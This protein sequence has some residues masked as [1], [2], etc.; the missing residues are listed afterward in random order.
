MEKRNY[1]QAACAYIDEKASFFEKTSDYIWDHPELSLKEYKATAWYCEKL[2]ELGYSCT[3]SNAR[4]YISKTAKRYGLEMTKYN[5]FV[6]ED[7][8]IRE[9]KEVEYISRKG[10]FNHIWMKYLDVKS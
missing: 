7:G 6:P 2:K 3:D 1:K 9:N 10:I 8:Q 5:S 4:Q